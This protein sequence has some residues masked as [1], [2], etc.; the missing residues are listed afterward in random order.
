MKNKKSI[1]LIILL[2]P[3]IL[4]CIAIPTIL[5]FI[6]NTTT[7]SQ[8]V[9][10]ST[11]NMQHLAKVEYMHK[12][13]ENEATIIK[14]DIQSKI[15]DKM[16]E[17]NLEENTDY[18]INGLEAIKKDIHLNTVQIRISS[19]ENSK[20]AT[21][22]F[23]I[24]LNTQE[25]INNRKNDPINIP[26]SEENGLSAWRASLTKNLIHQRSNQILNAGQ[27]N[28]VDIDY[29]ILNLDLIAPGAIFDNYNN[30]IIVK[31]IPNTNRL[32]GSFLI[33]FQLQAIT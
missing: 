4:S 26:K 6:A 15:D 7:N 13:N 20:K 27:S 32:E 2:V 1:K 30:K 16:S 5:Y 22:R 3:T 29:E 21:G 24:L 23:N 10:L 14:N 19:L 8:P 11:I 18:E 28:H 9:N 31:A 12:I 17:L 25:N 33:I